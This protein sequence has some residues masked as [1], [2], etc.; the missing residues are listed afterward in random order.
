MYRRNWENLSSKLRKKVSNLSRS[1]R[2]G[3][4]NEWWR[5]CVERH[6]PVLFTQCN[7]VCCVHEARG[8]VCIVCAEQ[9]CLCVRVWTELWL[10]W[11]AAETE[12]WWSLSWMFL[13]Q[14]DI[15][16]WCIFLNGWFYS[17]MKFHNYDA[18]LM[19]FFVNFQFLSLKILWLLKFEL[20]NFSRA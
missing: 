7:I 13:L 18:F 16:V 20:N 10:S 11:A 8:R 2:C 9:S 1:V 6:M 17:C 12:V 19:S 3:V 5:M 15:V 4:V 14:A